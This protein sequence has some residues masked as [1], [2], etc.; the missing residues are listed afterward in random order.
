MASG[1]IAV[2]AGGTWQRSEKAYTLSTYRYARSAVFIA[3][4]F[5]TAFLNGYRSSFELLVCAKRRSQLSRL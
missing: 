1:Q 3:S 4:S 2:S 5:V